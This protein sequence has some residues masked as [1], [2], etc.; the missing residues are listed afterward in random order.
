MASSTGRPNPSAH[1]GR[2]HHRGAGLQQGQVGGGHEPQAAHPVAEGGEAEAEGVAPAVGAGEGEGEAGAVEALHRVDEHVEALAGLHGADEQH[3]RSGEAVAVLRCGD[4]IGIGRVAGLHAEGDHP[5]ASG[6]EP[7]GHEVG[8][9]HLG[10]HHH[11][12][13][14]VRDAVQAPGHEPHPPAIEHLGHG[15][16][17]QVVHGGHEG[18]PLA[19][20]GDGHGEVHQVD[21]S[22]RRGHAGPAQVV[23]GVVQPRHPQSE[24]RG[25]DRGKPRVVGGP[26]GT[27]PIRSTSPVAAR[28]PASRLA[29]VAVPPGTLC[30]FC[31]RVVADPDGVGHRRAVSH[32]GAAVLRCRSPAT[33]SCRGRSPA[34]RRVA[35]AAISEFWADKH[36]LV[37][38][39]SGFLG[40]ARGAAGPRARGP[41]KVSTP[42][43]AEVDLHDRAATEAMF[44]AEHPDVVIHLAARV[45]GIGANRDHP[46]E[47]FYDNL[48]MGVQLHARRPGAPASA[49]SS[50]SAP[51]C[52]YPK[53]TPVPFRE[54]DLWNGYPEETNAPYGLAKKMLLVQAQAYRDQYGFNADLPAAGEPL[55]PA[56]QLRP[57]SRRTSSPR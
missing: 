39:T 21:R 22:R 36:V 16:G 48:M 5:Q 11:H 57:G 24:R 35:W 27:T 20:R 56:R 19:G 28:A 34:A 18:H 10:R 9:H 30:Q 3:V 53:F 26:A 38:G 42:G 49:S 46:A 8:P 15:E 14:L 52:A 51:I 17:Q 33:R 7:V 54:D 31:V 4:R 37:T 55:R 29:A 32:A 50:P 6:A 47:F 2:R 13:R 41:G 40:P 23:P 43:S 1:N 44:S 12:G 45:G 25:G